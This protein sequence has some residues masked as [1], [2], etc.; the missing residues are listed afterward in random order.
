MRG[1]SG[2]RK[3]KLKSKLM[4]KQKNCKY[5]GCVLTKENR[6]IDHVI[7]KVLL[8][9]GA[10][11]ISNLVLCCKDCNNQKGEKLQ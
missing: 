7:A 8:H 11:D 1:P 4:R 9:R 5:C 3:K 10:N 6:T 2:H